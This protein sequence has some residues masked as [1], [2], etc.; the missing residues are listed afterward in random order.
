[1]QD[2]ELFSFIGIRGGTVGYVYVDDVFALV[3]F[4]IVGTRAGGQLA[5]V[6][7]VDVARGAGNADCLFG[8]FFSSASCAIDDEHP[9]HSLLGTKV[10]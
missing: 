6:D 2:L 10:T 8:N 5:D 3:P 9:L 7:A 4:L 1:M